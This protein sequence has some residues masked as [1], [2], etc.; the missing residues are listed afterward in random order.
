VE[1]IQRAGN[2][3]EVIANGSSV[4]GDVVIMATGVAPR[5]ELAAAA[6]GIE[7]ADGAIPVT[8]DMRSARADV[9]AAG[10][11]CR[12]Q[13]VA[14]GRALRV[15]HWGDAL[16]QGEIAGMTAAGRHAAWD[17]VPGFWSTIGSRTLKYAAWG[18]GFDEARFESHGNGSFTVWYACEGRVVGVLTHEADN[19]YERGTDLIGQGASWS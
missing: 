5:G 11:V 13:N 19:D 8:A 3:F 1:R 18:D 7:L 2:E 15:E 6:P 17:Q 16:A 14:A 10:D 4:S 9:L 12:A